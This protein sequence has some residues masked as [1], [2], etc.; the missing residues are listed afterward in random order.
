[1]RNFP[2]TAFRLSVATLILAQVACSEK[3]VAPAVATTV[4]ANSSTTLTAAAGSVVSPAP[5]VLVKDQN[6][7]A[8]SGAM[9]TFTVVGGGGS[10][11]GA[12]V[13]TNASGIATVGGWT[14][15]TLVGANTLNASVGTLPAVTFT[16][17]S[18]SGA[19]ASL[20]K[21]AGDNQSAGSGTAVP[22]APSVVVKD[23]NGN[24]TP[25]VTVTFAVASGAGS[26]TGGTAT[27]S[28]SGV[29]TVGSWVLGNAGTNTLTASV[30]GLTPVTFTATAS[31]NLCAA[32]AAHTFGTTTSSSLATG[33]C[34]LSDGSLV[35][36]FSTTV[37]EAGAYLFRETAGFDAYLYLTGAD[38]ALIAEN[39]DE[40]DSTTNSAI[41][42]L[43]PAGSYLLGASSFNP[44][45]T[46]AYSISSSTT[47]T[48]V[49]NCELVFV[50]RGISTSQNVDTTD[51]LFSQTGPIYADGFLIF[52]QAGQ[53]VTISMSSSSVDSYLELLRIDGLRVAFN[54]NKDTSGTK[55]AQ[56]V[57][58]PSTSTYYAIFARTAVAAQTGPYTLIIQ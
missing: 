20:A 29:A 51:C 49:G 10:V 38:G 54:D 47:S 23:A 36:F 17:T 48:A 41:K 24:V 18:T 33:D 8:M 58:T 52:L 6:G 40:N 13:T 56:I 4:V 39:D 15:G 9:A 31:V 5:S 1:L 7:A 26:V 42:A 14:L 21:V 27:T 28:S 44:N 43:L 57:Y 22:V 34:Q 55:D 12:T 37:T 16:A 25:N 50:V 35:D 19:A 30:T 46:G 11:T 32:R 45:I 2:R 53:P 3:T